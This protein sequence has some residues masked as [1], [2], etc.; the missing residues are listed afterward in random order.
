L[1][2]ESAVLLREILKWIRFS[3][4]KEVSNALRTTLDSAQKIRIYHLSD[5]ENSTRDIAKEANVSDATVRNYWKLWA[6]T[7]IV[8]PIKAGTGDRYRHVFDLEELGIS[9]EEPEK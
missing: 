5:G 8:E 6:T 9:L 1:P 3:G 2:D 4:M 7:G